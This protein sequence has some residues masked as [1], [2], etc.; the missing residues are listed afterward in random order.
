MLESNELT[1]VEDHLPITEMA[2][3]DQDSVQ[4]EGLTQSILKD[5]F[6]SVSPLLE[7]FPYVQV[8]QFFVLFFWKINV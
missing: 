6:K 2:V 5:V 3:N 4:E 8:M 7:V 1:G